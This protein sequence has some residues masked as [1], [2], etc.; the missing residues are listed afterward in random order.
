MCV[1]ASDDWRHHQR[2]GCWSTDE[3]HLK[4]YV[5]MIETGQLFARNRTPDEARVRVDHETAR[6]RAG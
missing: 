2:L 4:H 3:A 5:W 1:V 6:R